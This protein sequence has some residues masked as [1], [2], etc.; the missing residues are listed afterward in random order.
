MP[1]KTGKDFAGKHNK[2]LHGHS[3]DIAK[4]TAN[5]ILKKTGD[6]GKAIRIAN[7]AGDK[8]LKKKKPHEHLYGKKD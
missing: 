3:A 5:A 2:K 1:W 8:A 4:S 6:E 7:A